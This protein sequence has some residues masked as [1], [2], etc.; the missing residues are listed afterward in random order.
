MSCG[1]QEQLGSG[2]RFVEVFS[3]PP[4]E[5]GITRSK[6]DA[7]RPIKGLEEWQAL[8]IRSQRGLEIARQGDERWEGRRR[9]RKLGHN[10]G[11]QRFLPLLHRAEL[12]PCQVR[13]QRAT[14]GVCAIALVKAA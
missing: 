12:C 14:S 9:A 11:Q 13:S 2:K 1:Q 10:H 4:I 7:H 3:H 5:I 6:D 8:R